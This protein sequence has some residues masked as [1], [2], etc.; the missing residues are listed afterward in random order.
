MILLANRSWFLQGY[1]DENIV[2]FISQ[3]IMKNTEESDIYEK[4]NNPVLECSPGDLRRMGRTVEE[5]LSRW[6]QADQEK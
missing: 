6:P 4:G 5:Y 3:G 1:I 2:Y